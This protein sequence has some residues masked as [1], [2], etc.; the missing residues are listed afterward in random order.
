MKNYWLKRVEQKNIRE[1]REHLGETIRALCLGNINRRTALHNLCIVYGFL[2][3]E[4]LSDEA[5]DDLIEQLETL[6]E[7]DE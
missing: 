6:L 5:I 2:E 4:D 1:I 7:G 3:M